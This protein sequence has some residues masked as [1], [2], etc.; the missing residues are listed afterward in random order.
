M[1]TIISKLLGTF[2]LGDTTT[3]MAMEAQVSSIGV[4]QSVTRDSPITV[5]TGDIVQAA[6]S[7]SWSVTGTVVLDLTDASGIFYFVHA[8]QG[9][10]MPFT[11]T[12]IGD[13][14]PT[15]AGTCIVDGWDTEELNAGAIVVSKF[16]WPV[17]GQ[18]TITPPAG[19]L[20]RD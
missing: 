8:N 2:Q 5:L 4:P 3:G 16:T 12:P 14:G 18:I 15:I 1:A 20:A 19:A 10:Q 9:T 6:A 13:T 17:Q 7:Y 11:F